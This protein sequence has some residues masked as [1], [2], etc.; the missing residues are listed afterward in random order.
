MENR[1]NKT[2]NTA[3]ITVTQLDY[4]RLSQLIQS[5]RD[6]NTIDPIYLNYLA[7]ELQRAVKVDSGSIAPDFVTMNSIVDI[8]FLDTGR[9]MQLRL[10]YPRNAD[11]GKGLVSV[12]SPLGC[13][14]LGFR[15]GDVVSFSAPKGEQSVL[16]TQLVYQPE[17]NGE[18]LI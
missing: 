17:A 6:S 11:F 14:L 10:V 15:A 12:L 9:A 13:A 2:A 1:T 7:V 4:G 3:G 5:L 18:D 16:I 8:K